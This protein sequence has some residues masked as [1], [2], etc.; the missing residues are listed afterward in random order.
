MRLSGILIFLSLLLL[1]A[2]NQ[3]DQ[4]HSSSA[5]LITPGQTRI[6]SLSGTI[7]EMLCA[8]GLEEYIVAT[9]VTSTYPPSVRELP[10]VGHNRN[11]SAERIMA[12]Q[13]TIVIGLKEQIKPELT[14]QLQGA[15]VKLM[16]Y[17]FEYSIESS[18]A[19]IKQLADAF[20]VADGAE[21]LSSRIDAE[22]ETV[23]AP[24]VRPRVLFIYAR[25]AGTLMVAGE[26][27]PPNTMI[28]LAGGENAATGFEDFKPLT[29]EALVKA[30]PDVILMFENGL[31]SLGGI[32][33]LLQIQ[34]MKET[35]AGKNRQII[36]MDGQFLTG[37]G[38]RVGE[39]VA[40]LSKKL[41]AVTV[42]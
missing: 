5:P 37:F 23:E 14:E 21:A 11:L 15:G 32:E 36:E 35:N 16:A 8:L 20:G 26:R 1:G 4:Q 31:E 38:P 2:C 34:G 9:D 42:P 40:F 27:T 29:A 7:T 19:L 33:G 17:D 13:P 3:G 18:K 22:L 41:N 12:Q 24:A 28:R 10:K 6:V 30:N 25:G 39:A